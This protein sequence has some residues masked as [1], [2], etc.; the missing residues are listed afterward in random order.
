[1]EL[2]LDS[3][4]FSEVEEADKLGFIAG[5]TT[6]PTFLYNEGITDLDA[7]IVKLSKMV[8]V[9]HVE[10]LGDTAEDIVKEAGRILGLGLSKDKTVFKIPVSEEGVK[11]CK[12]LTS[13]G[14]MVNVH[15]IYTLQQAYMAFAAGAT[16]VCILVGR[17]QDQGHDALLLVE[18]CVKAVERYGYKSKV[19]FSS[20][21]NAEH[22]RNALMLGAHTCTI[23]WKVLK[24]LPQ[25]HFTD[26]GIKQFVDH[27]NLMKIKAIDIARMENIKLSHKATILEALELMTKSKLGSIIILDDKD[28]IYRIFTD[29]DL[30]RNVEVGLKDV[31]HTKLSEL[32]PN[33][34]VTIDA[35]ASLMEITKIFKE[36]KVDNLIVMKAGKPYG[37]VDIQDVIKWI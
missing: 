10:A 14:M 22:V 23:P 1:M 4:K 9:L 37:I 29:G 26:I 7:A 27:T 24:M 19:M 30:R 18:Q 8:K 34:P 20:V 16:Y 32:E 13:Q 21:R 25:N 6:T 11:A 33:N 17:M 5:L 28:K 35:E 31:I 36:R 3:I 2:Y 15:L 12:M